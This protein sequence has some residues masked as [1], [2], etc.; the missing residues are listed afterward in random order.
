VLRGGDFGVST[1]VPLPA[2]HGILHDDLQEKEVGQQGASGSPA[3]L[4]RHSQLLDIRYEHSL[5]V[6]P[7][8][9]RLT[10]DC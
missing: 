1:Q 8:N 9:P 7:L 10:T 3:F 2:A 6:P 4:V 5:P